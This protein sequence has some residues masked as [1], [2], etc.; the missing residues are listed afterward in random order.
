[1]VRQEIGEVGADFF[2]SGLRRGDSDALA[3]D[4]KLSQI[5]QLWARMP[6]RIH[7]FMKDADDFNQLCPHHAEIDPVNGT[8]N[9]CPA[10]FAAQ[11]PQVQAANAEHR[12]VA[13]SG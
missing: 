7:P 10:R 12:L 1:M 8:A 6:D 5:K 13:G 2:E 11:V 4:Q 9:L 3:R